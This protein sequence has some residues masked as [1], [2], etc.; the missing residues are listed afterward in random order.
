[1]KFFYRLLCK[2]FPSAAEVMAPSVLT[3]TSDSTEVHHVTIAIAT[4]ACVLVLHSVLILSDSSEA[5]REISG[6]R[7]DPA[8]NSVRRHAHFQEQ[9]R[10]TFDL[11][12]MNHVAFSWWIFFSPVS[13]T[14]V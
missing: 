7:T 2:I 10:F 12:Q 9:N 13:T 4:S 1:M 3:W 14:S 11:L 8:R 6:G 5:E